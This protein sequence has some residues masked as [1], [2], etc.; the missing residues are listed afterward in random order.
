MVWF[1]PDMTHATASFLAKMNP[2]QSAHIAIPS[3][4]RCV[5]KRDGT[6]VPWDADKIIG[7]IALAFYD[8]QHDGAENPDREKPDARYGLDQHTFLK[9]QRI[10]ASVALM[11][12]LYYR[13][14]RHPTIE[15]I[16]D[17]VEK[18]IA[19]EGEWDVARSYIIYRER[20]AAH[21]LNHYA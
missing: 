14:G 16:Q 21:R 6:T 10:A 15:Q 8:V 9:V 17:N 7:A 4:A 13:T 3:T 20:K 2:R 19:A 5:V 18:A 12:E 1:L 11:L